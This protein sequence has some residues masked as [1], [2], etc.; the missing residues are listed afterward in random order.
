[1]NDE[2]EKCFPSFPLFIVTTSSFRCYVLRPSSSVSQPQPTDA[3]SL[4]HD[5]RG[6]MNALVLCSSALDD[7]LPRDEA[8]EFVDHIEETADRLVV[9][10]DQLES[11]S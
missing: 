11:M 5:I 10:L 2:T 7:S 8:I 9:L 6:R 4:R 3:R 1:M